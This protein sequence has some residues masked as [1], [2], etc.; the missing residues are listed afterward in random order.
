MIKTVI[1]YTMGR[2]EAGE[3][4]NHLVPSLKIIC[5][6]R[7]RHSRECQALM[8]ILAGLPSPGVKSYHFKKIYID[9]P[10]GW[11]KLPDNYQD[12]NSSPVW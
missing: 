9:D 2:R 11:E 12:L 7:G 8:P 1:N 5:R 4:Y 10:N 3:T 6:S